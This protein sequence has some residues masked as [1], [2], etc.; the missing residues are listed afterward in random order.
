MIF[1]GLLFLLGGDVLLACSLKNYTLYVE[2]HECG[3]C[4]AINTTVCSGTCFTQDTN[5]RGF[6]GKCFLIQRGCMHHSLVYHSAKMP[7]CLV[8]ID[9]FFFYPV[10]H[11]CR[12]TKCNT[13][14]NE[15]V[16]KPKHTASKCSEHLLHV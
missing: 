14:K 1:C 7:G 10:A 4:M 15:S 5:V 3:H 11:H 6:V 12:C 9:P 16:C 8:H 13:A 2:R